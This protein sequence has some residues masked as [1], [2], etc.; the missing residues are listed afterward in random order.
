MVFHYNYVGR[1]DFLTEFFLNKSGWTKTV[2]DIR[3]SRILFPVYLNVKLG[4][5]IAKST[6]L[7]NNRGK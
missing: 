1:L 2:A 4:C 5:N 7:Y 3:I 6:Y